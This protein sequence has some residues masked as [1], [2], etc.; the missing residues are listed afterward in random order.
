MGF[1]LRPL[2]SSPDERQKN[3]IL[4]L[5]YM[6]IPYAFILKLNTLFVFSFFLEC[7]C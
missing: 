2:A 6:Y 3:Q 4:I 7:C 1:K 5:N